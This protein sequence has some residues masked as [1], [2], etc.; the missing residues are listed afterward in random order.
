M[1]HLKKYFPVTGGV[2]GKVVAWV[3]AV[4]DVSFNMYEGESLGLVGESGC[5]K[6]TL[7][8]C[9]LRLIEP[10]SGRITYKGQDITGLDKVDLKDFRRQTSIIFQDPFLSLNPRMTIGETISEPYVI[11]GVPHGKD[12]DK[13]VAYWLRAVGLTPYHIYRYPHEFSG[14]QKQRIGIARAMALN[15]GFVMADEPVASLDLSVRA[16]IINLMKDLQ[17]EFNVTY[18]FVSHDL[19]VVRQICNRVLVMYLGKIVEAANAHELFDNPL[20]PY[21]RALLS[22]VPVPDP[23]SKR[24][25]IILKGD[26][27]TPLNPPNGCRFHPRCPIARPSCAKEEPE[28]INAGNEHWAACTY[29]K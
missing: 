14:G 26:V 19:A 13:L 28:M 3:H 2:F 7:G 15:P 6:T 9:L 5:G 18:L 11:H 29:T 22:A 12:K 25:R 1:E 21:T 20:H 10:S 4:D 24:T 17:K 23:E 27:P 16:S 8:R